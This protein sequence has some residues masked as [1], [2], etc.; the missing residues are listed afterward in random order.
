MENLQD[1]EPGPVWCHPGPRVQDGGR[2]PCSQGVSYRPPCHRV[3]R[4]PGHVSARTSVCRAAGGAPL[5]SPRAFCGSSRDQLP[6]TRPRR[7][8]LPRVPFRPARPCPVSLPVHH[9]PPASRPP[10]RTQGCLGRPTAGGSGRARHSQYRDPLFISQPGPW[11]GDQD[12]NKSHVTQKASGALSWEL[13]CSVPPALLFRASLLCQLGGP[14]L[15]PPSVLRG[16]P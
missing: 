4:G 1:S 16:P 14:S 13:G 12:T 8:P 15:G 5:T 3:P 11:E 9:G 2:R 6:S 7:V 10:V